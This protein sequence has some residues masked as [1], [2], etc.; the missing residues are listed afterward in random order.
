MNEACSVGVEE[1]LE[2]NVLVGGWVGNGSAGGI[3][4]GFYGG[5]GRDRSDGYYDSDKG[6]ESIDG[7]YRKM[8]RDYPKDALLLGNYDGNA[9]PLYG[10]LIWHRQKDAS[11]AQSYFHQAVHSAPEDQ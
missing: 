2:Q 4:S 9:L 10:A 1:N 11:R 7:Y 3:S 6:S 8:I 5:G